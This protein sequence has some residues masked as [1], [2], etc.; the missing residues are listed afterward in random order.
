MVK[1]ALGLWMP[2]A[3]QMAVIFG[4]SSI[5]NLTTLPG[6]L[7]DHAGHFVGYGL[8]GL[9][10]LRAFASAEWTGV[11]MRAIVSAW[12]LA[13]VYGATDEFHQRFVPGRTPAVDDW[14]ADA[15]GAAAAI[16]IVGV[17]CAGRRLENREV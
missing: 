8:L 10:A 3:A 1:R 12:T 17:A 15:L 2:V 16:L 13:A 14:A 5:P 6:N 11:T 9:A 4:A 7:S